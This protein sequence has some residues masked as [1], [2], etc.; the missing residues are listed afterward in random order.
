MASPVLLQQVLAALHKVLQLLRLAGHDSCMRIAGS[1]SG[2]MQ[3]VEVPEGGALVGVEDVGDVV[4]HA[5]VLKLQSPA[6][7][8][9]DSLWKVQ[10]Q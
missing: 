6:G 4:D 10:Q 5:L 9:V 8:A 7:A 3:G 1:Q 2:G